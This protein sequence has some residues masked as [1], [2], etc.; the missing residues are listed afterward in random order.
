MTRPGCPGQDSILGGVCTRLE[1]IPGVAD[2]KASLVWDPP[3][4][5]ERMSA[6][7]E[8]RFGIPALP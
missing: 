6:A 5:P 1:R 7:L 8:A 4:T 3:W 2:S